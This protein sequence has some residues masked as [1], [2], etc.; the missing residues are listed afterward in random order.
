M[1]LQ[2]TLCM[3]LVTWFARAEQTYPYENIPG[4][5]LLQAHAVVRESHYTFTI[6]GIDQ[7]TLEVFYAITIL[8]QQGDDM[9]ALIIP[10]DKQRKIKNIS[11][12]VL[13][14]NG[15]LIR[16]IKSKDIADFSN[17]QG[18]LFE[19]NRVKYFE[20]TTSEYPYTI[21]YTYEVAFDGLLHYPV[22]HPQNDYGMAV[23]KSDFTVVAPQEIGFRYK[24]VNISQQP[25]ITS[26]DDKLV[27]EWQLDHL[28]AVK[29]ELWSPYLDQRTPVVHTAP[30][31][32]KFEGYQGTM[33]TWKDL[34]KWIYE[35]NQ[36][37][38][39]LSE[40]TIRELRQL[41][42]GLT[43]N[44]EIIKKVYAYM[45]SKTRYVSI[46]L[47]I[48]GYQPMEA[49]SVDQLG[50]GD[51][52]ALTNYMQSLLKAVDINSYYTLVNAGKYARE[53]L[54]DFPSTQF[55]HVILC[56]PVERDTLWL[57]CTSQTNPFGFL[58]YFTSDRQV[59]V[60]DEQGGHL[61][62]TPQYLSL[63]NGQERNATVILD[64]QGH[65]K[66][67][68]TTLY[69]GLQYEHIEGIVQQPSAEQQK[70]IYAKTAIPGFDL[71]HYQYEAIKE[72]IPAIEEKLQLHLRH[73][74]TESG[75]RFFFHPN[76]LNKVGMIPSSVSQREC[77][78]VI[79]FA[80]HDTDVITY[81]LPEAMHIEHLPEAVRINSKFGEYKVEY[82]LED[83][84]VVYTRS[85][86]TAAGVFPAK[87][88][89]ELREFYRKVEQVDKTHIVLKKAT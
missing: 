44:R 42:A 20:F 18:S 17:N 80:Y 49:A 56:V 43:D 25:D 83:N 36:G 47:G 35:L 62:R 52:K 45:Q 31:A 12:Q 79:R 89:E 51:C 87:D 58:G 8:D 65:G 16:K 14:K 86:K 4:S 46:Q 82:V 53:I 68:V 61:A 57:E 34:G 74:A 88:Y 29:Q 84:K 37:R 48:G 40:K 77:E 13:D 11:G 54:D 5:L 26:S 75:K 10:Y 19:D 6:Q 63:H 67:S 41:T 71:L 73:Y 76:I 50:Y 55:N 21:Q 2:I 78:V 9:A 24:E 22:W 59:L 72:E 66:A 23:E 27:Y 15:E 85:F 30:N 28:A 32:F 69:S 39:Q 7:G 64:A 60:I 70:L 3:L 38:D 33:S 1:K 81:I